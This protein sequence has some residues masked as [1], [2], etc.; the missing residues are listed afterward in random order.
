MGCHFLLQGI[1]PGS[2]ALQ[3]DALPSE[4]LGK[5]FREALEA[6]QPPNRDAYWSEAIKVNV[7]PGSQFKGE[8]RKAE[9]PREPR[10][11][12]QEPKLSELSERILVSFL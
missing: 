6:S 2:P 11:V 10:T 4:T 3:T 8:Q 9:D 12:E 1:E 5:P 7:W